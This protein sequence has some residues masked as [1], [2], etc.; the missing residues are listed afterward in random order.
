MKYIK[1]LIIIAMVLLVFTIGI[2]S[3]NAIDVSNA[4]KLSSNILYDEN[5][6]YVDNIIS[7]QFGEASIKSCEYLYNLDGSN[8][9]LYVIFDK[10][11]AVYNKYN[12]EMLEY[13]PKGQLPY[14]NTEL[15]KYYAGPSN[16]LY[17]KNNKFIDIKSGNEINISEQFMQ[18]YSSQIRSKI[19]KSSTSV[20]SLLNLKYSN[21]SANKKA[22]DQGDELIVPSVATGTYI[23]NAHYFLSEP[24]HG[25][26]N[27]KGEYGNKNTGTCGPVAAQILLTYN[28]YYNDRRIIENKFLNGYDDL[29]NSVVDQEKNPNYCEDPMYMSEWTLGSRSEDT[30]ANSFYSYV[31]ESIMEPG[32]DGSTIQE[33][34]NGIEQILNTSIGNNSYEIK[35]EEASWLFGW[36]PISSNKII[37][38]IDRGN[39]LIVYTSSN[40]GA[41]DH[42]TVA[43]GYQDY[44]YPNGDTYSGYV[45]HYGW[46]GDTYVWINSSWCDGFISLD[47]THSHNYTYIGGKYNEKKCMECGYRCYA[48]D[49]TDISFEE[50]TIIGYEGILSGDIILPGKINGKKINLGNALLANQTNI[51]SVTFS[52]GLK[53]IGANTFQGCTS[54]SSIS[55][56]SSLIRIGN[57]AFFGCTELSS[58]NFPGA[59]EEIG[60]NAFQNCVALQNVCVS[61]GDAFCTIGNSAFQDCINLSSI[62]T[63]RWTI[64]GYN[65]FLN[66]TS[67]REISASQNII[68]IFNAAF[69]NCISLKNIELS[70]SFMLGYDAFNGC[71]ALESV[72]LHCVYDMCDNVFANCPNLTVYASEYTSSVDKLIQSG[73]TVVSNC[74]IEEEAYVVSINTN[75]ITYGIN[76][77]INNPMREDYTFDGWYVAADFSGTK[78]ENITSAPQGTLYAK[79]VKKSACVA[80]GTLIT[81]ADGT[82]KVVE[83][84]TGDE[85]LLVWDL[86]NGTFSAAPILFIDSDP[87]RAYE[88]II[89]TFADGTEVKVIDE[90]GFW[91][92]DL[93]EYVFIRADAAKYIGD[94]FN[95]QTV[96]ANGNMTYT[97]VEL[98]S[99][100]IATEY[101]T[102]WSPVTYGHLCY[103]VNGMLSM[104][105]ATTGLINIFE[106]NSDTMTID[107]ELYLADIAE[108]GLFTYEEF[109]EI[110]AIPEEIFNAFNGQHLKVA[111]GKG[112]IDLN[113]IATLVERYSTFFVSENLIQEGAELKDCSNH[114][115]HY[116]HRC[117]RKHRINKY[118]S[119][120]NA[121]GKNRHNLI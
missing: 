19:L 85:M 53:S 115:N 70:I 39:P 27:K 81:L 48:Y 99:V 83:D 2:F 117:G 116:G 56:P 82:Q 49:L 110:I 29:T 120:G 79:W 100:S 15:K 31:I 88:V 13:S 30:G 42:A 108:Y 6:I 112:L 32:A 65:A 60:A 51:T 113:E 44:T 50:A 8:D 104:P 18:I 62:E 118:Q 3:G 35:W 75:N 17:E 25:D 67:L 114:G 119:K 92:M 86:F 41:G 14:E 98:V 7:H 72:T 22:P 28:N 89:L 71:G 20:Q 107:E 78:F 9:Y 103:Y 66:C 102:A 57:G 23:E 90:H 12:F 58:V 109:V 96:D 26:N 95:K 21:I 87:M 69:A 45:V 97:A 105:G 94:K 54:L 121:Y 1:V 10:G 43:Y 38:E 73:C 36:Q 101:T 16:Y 47:I 59:V 80:Q 106:V 91:N 34:A 74:V 111:I 24:T 77:I 37:E 64:I 84:L 55:L 11:Y 61:E 33:V 52:D 46:Q 63:L 93:N 40:L 68:A 5:N 76:N 4:N